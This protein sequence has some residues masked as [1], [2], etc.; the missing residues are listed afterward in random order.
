MTEGPHTHWIDGRIVDD[1][2]RISGS[3]WV[4]LAAVVLLVIAVDLTLGLGRNDAPT[5]AGDRVEA[6]DVRAQLRAAATAA[7]QGRPAFVLVGDSVLAGDVMAASVPD[8]RSQRV[9]DHMHAELGPDSDAALRQVAF[10]GLLPVDALRVLA[11]LD[12]VDPD[13]EVRFVLELNLRYF[14]R[15]YAKQR[16]CTRAEL[17]ELGVSRAAAGT[18]T[19]ARA[20]LRASALVARDWLRSRAPIRRHWSRLDRLDLS[21]LDGLTV[22]RGGDSSPS[23]TRAEGLARVQ[24]HYRDSTLASEH[25]QVEALIEIVERLRVRDRK[26]AMFFTPLD[27]G[28]VDATL[29]GNG[30]GRRQELIAA[31][32]HERTTTT[33]E[34]LDL[35]HPLFGSEYFLDHVHLD[36]EGNRLLAI[37]LL[38]ELGLP[39][40]ER[41]FAWMMIHDE[42]HD[43]SLV[44]RR[45]Q[46]Y[47]D[48]SAWRALFRAPEGVAVSRSGE[49]IVIA[50]TENHAL[51]QL[52]GS[53][54]IVERLAGV[55][56]RPGHVDGRAL[57]A[58]LE[59]PSSPEII[60]DTVYFLD[61]HG[62]R[63]RELAD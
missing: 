36:P 13:G 26:A 25:A 12:R 58:R 6:V 35:D 7:E 43:R 3:P 42:D 18:L 59:G 62:S 10:D 31:L 30:V 1:E 39:L 4:W 33:V 60:D 11:E 47:A 49:W 27:D 61:G 19:Q 38:H 23:P 53:M 57:D 41:P 54:Q 15:H 55:P 56:R 50:D 34:L 16:E 32:I 28:F 40:R 17:C 5:V 29:P 51:R 45:G 9:I 48:G 8:W 37:N 21:T 52:R 63:V 44:H 22:A 14:S 46:G 2:P 20:G 24:A